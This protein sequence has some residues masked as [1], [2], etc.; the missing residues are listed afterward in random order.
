[1]E[2]NDKYLYLK[3]LVTFFLI[4]ALETSVANI[5]ISFYFLSGVACACN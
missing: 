2:R 4:T 3:N 1:M 5:K